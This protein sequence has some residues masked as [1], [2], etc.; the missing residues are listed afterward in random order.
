MLVSQLL[1]G[2]SVASFYSALIVSLV[3]GL[4]NIFIR[5]ILLVL[6]LPINL[7]TFGFFTFVING[8]L[9]WFVSTFIKGFNVDGILTGIIASA[10]VTLFVYFGDRIISKLD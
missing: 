6:T 9:F 10:I 5:P 8:I 1:P 2:V 4:I 3:L 7:L